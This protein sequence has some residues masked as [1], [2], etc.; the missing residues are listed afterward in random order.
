MFVKMAVEDIISCRTTDTRGLFR[1]YYYIQVLLSA[2]GNISKILWPIRKKKSNLAL[3]SALGNIF[4][5]LWPIGRNKNNKITE[6]REARGNELREALNIKTNS[7]LKSRALRDIFE[8]FDEKM[9]EW[10]RKTERPGFSDRNV[11]SFEGVTVP[12]SSERLRTFVPETWTIIYCGREFKLSPAI[13]AVCGLYAEIQLKICQPGKHRDLLSEDIL[14][15]L[16][17]AGSAPHRDRR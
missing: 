5:T 15:E 4:R 7:S 6:L 12:R 10:F 9:D 16:I 13:I 14:Q 8:H 17:E 3:L 1:E 2:L 11:G